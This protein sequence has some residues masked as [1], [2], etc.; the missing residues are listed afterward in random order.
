MTTPLPALDVPAAMLSSPAQA[1]A[2]AE[3]SQVLQGAMPF[4]RVLRAYWAETRYEVLRVARTPI[5]L[6]PVMV[7]PVGLFLLF[8]VVFASSMDSNPQPSGGFTGADLAAFMFV[9][10][11]TMGAVMPG[12]FSVGQMLATERDQGLLKLKRAQPVPAG[13]YLIAKVLMQ[14]LFATL[15]ASAIAVTALIASKIS[16]SAVQMIGIVGLLGV[17]S[18]PFCAIGLFV[19]AYASAKAAPGFLWLAFFPMMY[20]SGMFIPLPGKL[21]LQ[22]G[23]WP[24]FHL[25]QLAYAIVGVKQAAVVPPLMS[26]AFLAGVT[27]IFGGLALYRLARKG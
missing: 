21:A 24:T 11:A 22:E 14:L 20:L 1:G 2:A 25:T 4:G 27:V 8:G 26:V 13:A 19:G 15:A 17:G 18:I 7:L 16:W 3:G 5:F 23:L 6:I 10:M 12:L 9:G